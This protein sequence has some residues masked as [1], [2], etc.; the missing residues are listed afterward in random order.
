MIWN[1]TPRL[2][3]KIQEFRLISTIKI[4]LYVT[5]GVEHGF[6]VIIEEATMIY[7]SDEIYPNDL[8]ISIN[9]FSLDYDFKTMIPIIS[10][11]VLNGLSPEFFIRNYEDN[12]WSY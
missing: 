11:R 5:K 2:I 9:R 6:K 10:K 7:L 8:D 4:K 3:F 1:R 12:K